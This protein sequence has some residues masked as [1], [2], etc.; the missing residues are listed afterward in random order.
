MDDAQVKAA[1]KLLWARVRKT[2]ANL[3]A[4]TKEYEDYMKRSKEG[5]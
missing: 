2:S 1:K 3:E 4:K 5:K